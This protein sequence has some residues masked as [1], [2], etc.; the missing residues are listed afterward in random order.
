MVWYRTGRWRIR[1]QEYV[2]R[3]GG[4]CSQCGWKP[5]AAREY[6]AMDLHHKDPGTKVATVSELWTGSREKLEVELAKCVLI[7]ANCHRIHHAEAWGDA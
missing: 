1:K 3:M 6:A 7:C 2:D 5:K 4:A